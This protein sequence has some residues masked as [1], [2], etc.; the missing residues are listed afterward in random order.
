MSV[1]KNISLFVLKPNMS[2]NNLHLYKK[3]I[4]K[5]YNNNNIMMYFLLLFFLSANAEK[6]CINCK[7]FIP[8][9]NSNGTPFEFF[10]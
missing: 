4:K 3:G 10:N 8:L 6:F 2:E 7:H 1:Q 9:K 5:P